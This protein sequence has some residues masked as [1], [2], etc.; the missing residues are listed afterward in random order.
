MG[1][2]SR[3]KHEPTPAAW[4]PPTAPRCGCTR[5]LDDEL[6]A[7]VVPFTAA[8]VEDIGYTPEPATV[9]GLLHPGGLSVEATDVEAQRLTDSPSSFVWTVNI[10][11]DALVHCDSEAVDL[12][13]VIA[14]QPG[15]DDVERLDHEIFLVAAPTLCADGMLAAAA[16]ALL[17]D[18]VRLEH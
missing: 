2:F 6:L 5:H 10:Y 13:A 15:V 14:E 16:L 12:D 17:D 4:Q 3:R 8:L 1:L 7:A 18:R 9:G 11:D